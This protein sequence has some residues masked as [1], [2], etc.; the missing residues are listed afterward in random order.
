MGLFL[1]IQ[2]LKLVVSHLSGMKSVRTVVDN[3]RKQARDPDEPL[4]TEERVVTSN[5]GAKYANVPPSA[6]R[7]VG[8]GDPGE[9]IVIEVFEDH[10]RVRPAGEAGHD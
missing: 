9:D 1:S 10:I 6:S 8:F 3:E 5:N 7:I 4:Y 2:L